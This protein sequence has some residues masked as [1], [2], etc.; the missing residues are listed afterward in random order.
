MNEKAI[1]RFN[2]IINIL[3]NSDLSKGM[4][5]KKL[6]DTIEKLGPTFIKLGQIMSTRVD[7]LPK[8]YTDALATL[9]SNITPIPYK[10]IES[11]LNKN[12]KHKDKIF[13]YINKTPIGAASIAEVHKARL[14]NGEEIILK[15]KRPNID[16]TMNLDIDLFKKAINVLHIDKF[17]RIMDL[18]KVLK[19]IEKTTKEE[20][21][22]NIEKEHLLKFRKLNKDVPYVYSP[23]VYDDLCTDEIIAMEYIPGIKINDVDS[24]KKEGYDLSQ[25]ASTLCENYIKC[26]LKDGF[27]HADPH[28]DNILIYDNTITYIDMGMMGT[29]SNKNKMLLNKCINAIVAK[30]Y[31]DV[32]RILVDMSTK[33]DEVNMSKLTKDIELILESYGVSN[34]DNIDVA[35]FFKDMLNMLKNNHLELN[36]D[37]TMLIRGICVIEPVIETLDSKTSLFDVL[38]RAS[39]QN[40]LDLNNIRGEATKIVRN[41]KDLVSIPSEVSSLIKSINNGETK[42]KVEMSDS[43][44]QVDKLEDLI[45]EAI[46]GFI[47]GCLII[48]V[49][50]VQNPDLKT[51][52]TFLIVFLSIFLILKMLI[53]F[54]RKGY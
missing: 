17:V 46:L 25:I 26:A 42:F 43:Y 27:F 41:T 4:T 34:L 10:K 7:M 45:H 22:F 21:N 18:N 12:Y 48:A 24:L 32:A 40:I 3:K 23:N 54:I 37:V 33:L 51:F 16:E 11:I 6:V 30:D 8:E 38:L 9:R 5:P 36:D 29:L 47:D 14:K 31:M 15:I 13:S 19:E 35:G 52:A 50:M 28:P 53:D 39:T 1:H 44:K 49:N 2:E 20:L